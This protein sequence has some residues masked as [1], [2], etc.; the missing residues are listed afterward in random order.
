MRRYYMSRNRIVLYK[1]YFWVF[2][3]WV[4]RSMSDS[5]LETVKC[6]L[7]EENRGSKFRSFLLGTWDGL[8]GKMGK[9][10]GL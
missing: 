7:G 10:E 4:L 1:N 5:L 3:R 8:I 2:P 9:R 6:F